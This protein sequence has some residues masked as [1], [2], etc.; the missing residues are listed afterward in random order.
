MSNSFKDQTGMGA[1]VSQNTWKYL[2]MGIVSVLAV[3]LFIPQA[4]A[5][6]TSNTQH[7]LSHIYNF[8]DG[9]EAKTNNLPTD[10]ASNTIVNTRASQ[11]SVAALQATADGIDTKV[12]EIQSTIGVGG[13]GSAKGVIVDT[14]ANGV[15]GDQSIIEVLPPSQDIIYAGEIVVMLEG[16]VSNLHFVCTFADSPPIPIFN[17]NE[18]VSIDNPYPRA[19]FLCNGLSILVDHSTSNPISV[20][21]NVVYKEVA[22]E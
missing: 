5:H 12:T 14:I 7:M 15:S 21:A 16:S 20:W 19:T 3:S 10:P 4:S 8:V 9:V 2:S 1:M 17:A 13:S 11:T 18:M 6:I 22:A